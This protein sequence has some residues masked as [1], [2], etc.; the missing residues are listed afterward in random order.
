[1]P[2]PGGRFEKGKV[3]NPR[4]RPKGCKDKYTKIR[5]AFFC[6]FHELGKE[7]L[8]DF[9]AKDPSGYYRVISNLLPKEID[10]NVNGFLKV[11]MVSNVDE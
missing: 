11:E 1:M 4:G 6:V 5:D 9:A 2:G 8:R 7:G 10:A 3:A